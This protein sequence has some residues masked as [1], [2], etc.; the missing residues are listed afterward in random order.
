MKKFHG[1]SAIITGSSRGIGAQIARELAASGAEVLI[2]YANQPSAAD[3]VV[4]EIT[5]K[6]GNAIAFR[7]DVSK[8]T[9]VKSMFDAAIERFGK[10]DYLINNA[11]IAIFKPIVTTTDDDFERLMDINL[12]GVFHTMREAATR[13]EDKGRIVNFSSTVTRLMMPSY[14]IYSASKAAVEQ[15]SRVFA[16]EMGHRGITVNSIAP[17]PTNTEL[18]H[19][20]KSEETVQ[21]LAQMAALGRIG[22]PEDISRV[23]LFL[24]SEDAGWISGQSIA[25]NGGFA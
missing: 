18:F 12:K 9:E 14:G 8:S 20:G 19:E 7:A 17:G 5:T 16:K 21:R 15:M 11:G 25:A 4:A 3:Q 13:L 6:G 1:K 10:I 24:L 22:E 2:N 23:V